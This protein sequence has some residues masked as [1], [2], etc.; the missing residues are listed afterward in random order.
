MPVSMVVVLSLSVAFGCAVIL[1]VV[2]RSLRQASARIDAILR[3]ELDSGPVSH[4]EPLPA[5]HDRA[6]S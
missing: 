1:V 6:R 3:D 5:E 2:R 4:P